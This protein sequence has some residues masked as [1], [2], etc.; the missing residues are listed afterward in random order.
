MGE[1]GEKVKSKFRL[2]NFIVSINLVFPPCA[3]TAVVFFTQ[4]RP[5]CSKVTPIWDLAIGDL[6]SHKI[7]PIFFSN[8]SSEENK[9]MSLHDRQQW[10]KQPRTIHS[11]IV[12]PF[13][14]C[15][16]T[17]VGGRCKC[18]QE[19]DKL[20]EGGDDSVRPQNRPSGTCSQ[21]LLMGFFFK[22]ETC[23]LMHLILCG[24]KAARVHG[25]SPSNQ[26]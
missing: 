24:H 13:I 11:L 10:G 6:V 3:R 14:C 2:P 25:Q 18:W 5:V 7:E 19:R 17:A 8:K 22:S 20:E 16:W 4:L 23:S 9:K 21:L 12:M 1:Q 26:H 15:C